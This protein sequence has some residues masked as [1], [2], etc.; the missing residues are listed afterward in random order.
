MR[1]IIRI[2]R[3]CI[4]AELIGGPF[5]RLMTNSKD[6]S[7]SLK[8]TSWNSWS[9]NI[10]TELW[11]SGK[12]FHLDRFK[13]VRQT[14]ALQYKLILIIEHPHCIIPVFL[15]RLPSFA[16]M[17]ADFQKCNRNPENDTLSVWIPKMVRHVSYPSQNSLDCWKVG[18]L[19]IYIVFLKLWSNNCK[20]SAKKADIIMN[21]K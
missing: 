20:N 7:V 21:L 16:V 12:N 5:Y 15:L 8:K 2:R 6:S 18:I 9:Q 3:N 4:L 14:Q 10:V 17:S 1:V 11:C 19:W 13:E